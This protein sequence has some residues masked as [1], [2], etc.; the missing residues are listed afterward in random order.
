MHQLI[1]TAYPIIV[2]G[3][4]KSSS[5]KGNPVALTEQELVGIL[6]KAC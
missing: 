3:A 6:K 2:A 1:H 4:E 5:M